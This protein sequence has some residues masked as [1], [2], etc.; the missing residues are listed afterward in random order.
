MH[1]GA[2]HRALHV[3]VVREALGVLDEGCKGSGVQ[4]LDGVAVRSARLVHQR[5]R[6]PFRDGWVALPAKE[7]KNEKKTKKTGEQEMK[8]EEQDNKRR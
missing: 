2:R 8:K 1:D 5:A 6:A 3:G 4:Q 7:K